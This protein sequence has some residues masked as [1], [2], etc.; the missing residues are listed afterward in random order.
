MG[1]NGRKTGKQ[2]QALCMLVWQ[3][4]DAQK[5]KTRSG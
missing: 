5:D 4:V 3:V 1:R 2:E